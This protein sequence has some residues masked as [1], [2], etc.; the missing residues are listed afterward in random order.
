M[1]VVVIIGILSSVMVLEMRGTFEDSILRANARKIID[2]CDAASNRAIALNQAQILRIEPGS[3]KYVVRAKSSSG[4]SGGES[5]ADTEQLTS[6]ELDTRVV[7]EMREPDSDET[8]DTNAEPANNDDPA[9]KSDVYAVSFYPDGTA[10]A[11]EFFFRDR[12]GVEIFLRLNP[13]TSRLRALETAP[14]LTP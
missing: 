11:R 4:G 9:S 5:S 2:V 14:P 10:D 6:G 12:A 1:I 3:G 8:S 7:L 13:S